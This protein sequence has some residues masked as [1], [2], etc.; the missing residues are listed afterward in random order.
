VE[1]LNKDKGYW[2]TFD[3]SWFRRNQSFLLSWLN[4]SWVKQKISRHILRIDINQKLTE[5][6][7]NYHISEISTNNHK[8]TFR[9]HD[10]YSKRIYHSFF[11]YWWLLHFI[12]WIFLDRFVPQ[13]SFGFDELVTRPDDG[14]DASACDGYVARVVTAGATLTSIRTG[15]G[16]SLSNI[17]TAGTCIRMTCHATESDKYYAT[18][19]ASFS[20]NTS[21]LTAGATISAAVLSLYSLDTYHANTFDTV[22]NSI[23]VVASTPL[24][25]GALTTGDYNSFG[26]TIYSTMTYANYTAPNGFRD[27]TLDAAGRATISKTGISVLGLRIG[28][29]ISGTG[30]TWK[31]DADAAIGIRWADNTG[32]TSD[33]YLTV[34]YTTTPATVYKP[35]AIFVG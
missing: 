4:G 30:I 34:T 25:P 23:N 12:D 16:T 15:S 20:F 3:S 17:T 7:P 35:S 32:T 9:T 21:A 2:K 24:N 8:A 31:A 18:R 19:R 14:A 26:T 10:K 33:P 13:Y 27:F 1:K 29:D 28:S 5:I 11:L 6:G 22:D